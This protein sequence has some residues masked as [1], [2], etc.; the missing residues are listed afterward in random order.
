MDGVFEACARIHLEHA[1]QRSAAEVTD[2]DLATLSSLIASSARPSADVLKE[3]SRHHDPGDLFR[4]CCLRAVTSA[5]NPLIPGMTLSIRLG[6]AARQA[7]EGERRTI[8]GIKVSVDELLLE[9]LERLPRTVRGF[10]DVGGKDACT[11]MF[12]PGLDRPKDERSDLGGPLEMIVSSQQQMQAFCEVPLVMDY[13]TSKFTMGLPNLGDTEG[14]LRS[15]T[16]LEYLANGQT[17]GR[18][19]GLV[20]ADTYGLCSLP[21]FEPAPMGWNLIEMLAFGFLLL[22][23]SG[24]L[25]QAADAESPNLVYLPGAQFIVAGVVAAPDN[26]YRVPAMRMALDFVVYVGMVGALSYFVLFQDAG[27]SRSD[28][29]ST[30]QWLGWGEAACALTFI[31]VCK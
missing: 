6:E 20:L 11:R 24:V 5:E 19:N 15:E 21:W 22:V 16:Q 25:L 26:Y 1:S 18:D 4:G 14:V 12:E 13:L 30:S 3:L 17:A 7:T 28:D 23:D 9:I 29:G 10:D 8:T 2:R 31:T 27:G